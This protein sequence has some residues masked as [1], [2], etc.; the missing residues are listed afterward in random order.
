MHLYTNINAGFFVPLK[1]TWAIVEKHFYHKINVQPSFLHNSV[2]GGK[3]ET[4]CQTVC[5][6]TVAKKLLPATLSYSSSKQKPLA[7]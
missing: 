6:A 5:L 4:Q 1:W 3:C 2:S 7:S